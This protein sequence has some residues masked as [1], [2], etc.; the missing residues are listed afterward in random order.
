MV[1]AVR[2]QQQQQRRQR[3]MEERM[4]ACR[5][6]GAYYSFAEADAVEDLQVKVIEA[7]G[8]V[9]VLEHQMASSLNSNGSGQQQPGRAVSKR[10]GRSALRRRC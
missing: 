5:A 8:R 4:A 6:R 2:Q 3:T 1:A 9:Q 7:E 10:S